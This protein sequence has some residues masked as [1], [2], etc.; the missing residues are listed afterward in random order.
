MSLPPASYTPT[1][2]SWPGVRTK[3]VW[4]VPLL[5]RPS[6]KNTTCWRRA[7]RVFTSP[8]GTG[9]LVGLVESLVRYTAEIS[10]GAKLPLKSSIQPCRSPYSSTMLVWFSTITSLIFSASSDC[11]AAGEAI[12]AQAAAR[13]MVSLC[14]IVAYRGMLPCFLAGLTT[15]LV[16][17]CWRAR[18]MRK[19]VLRGSITSSM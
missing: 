13:A 11:A 5:G 2:L 3:L 14:V 16:A 9:Y 1:Q 10:R 19:R 15:F 7:M 17:S 8:R 18:M 4:N 12:M 6:V